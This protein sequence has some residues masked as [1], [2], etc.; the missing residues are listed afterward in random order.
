M[1]NN[2]CYVNCDWVWSSGAPEN[3]GGATGRSVSN[4]LITELCREC[5]VP[6]GHSD[7]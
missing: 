7:A 2:V 5:T 4:V 6:A 3:S 1:S